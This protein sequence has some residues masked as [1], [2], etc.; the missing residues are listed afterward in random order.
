MLQRG[1]VVPHFP[2]IVGTPL[3][4]GACFRR[5]KFPEGCLSSLDAA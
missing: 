3:D 2:K 1:D 5:E 4:G